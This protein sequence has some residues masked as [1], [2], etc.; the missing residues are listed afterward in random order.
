MARWLRLSSGVSSLLE[1]YVDT[2]LWSSSYLLVKIG[3]TEVSPLTLVSLRYV[4]ASAILL[5]MAVIQGEMG[6]LRV[7]N[8]LK[9]VVLG[10]SGYARAQGLQCLGL[11]YLPAVSVTFILSF[12]PVIVLVLGTVFLWEKP[13]KLQLSGIG[14]VLLGAYLF[15]DAPLSGGGLIGL[16][17]TLLSG[18]GW[19]VYLVL[20]RRLFI[21][22]KVKPLGFTSATMGL[23]TI[24][25]AVTAYSV[26]RLPS[27]SLQGWAIILWLGVVNTAF[28]FFLWNHALQRL[29]AFRIAVLQNTML[30]QI[31][32]LSW[33][34]LGE[35]M[36]AMKI[37]PIALVFL[38]VLIVQLKK[39]N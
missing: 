12:T 23:G 16:P 3:L 10:L 9:L 39:R 26:E 1:A 8:L 24:V 30:I 5:P 29:E 32:I 35:R 36:T 14:I 22:K 28:A 34:F 31:A 11:F 2:L 17:I 27:V 20:G 33:L 4:V 19:A 6:L 21:E 13:T 15:F 7:G 18:I 38:G 37:L 25:I